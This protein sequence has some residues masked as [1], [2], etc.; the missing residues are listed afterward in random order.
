MKKKEAKESI[1]KNINTDH[2]L[3][4][5]YSMATTKEKRLKHHK[6]KNNPK[7]LLGKCLVYIGD[8]TNSEYYNS[9]IYITECSNNF[10]KGLMI[11]KL[12]YGNASIECKKQ[13]AEDKGPISV[14]YEDLYKGGPLKPSTGYVLFPTNCYY[15]RAPQS[16][17]IGDISISSSF[18]VLQDIIEDEGP[19]KKIIAMG[20]F[21]WNH[22]EL[23]WEIY[24]NR[25]LIIN[26]DYK[27]IFETNYADRWQTFKDKS[28]I[29][30]HSYIQKTGQA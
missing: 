12:L 30:L 2:S 16:I 15:S 28:G 20:H 1:N 23:E 8:N 3:D 29:D 24:N 6:L 4:K 27:L 21:L 14:V 18:G 13:L 10:V 7:N 19:E 26:A 9:V 5:N 22:G 25:W 11:N 17:T